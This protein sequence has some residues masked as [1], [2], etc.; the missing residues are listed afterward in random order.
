M[1]DQIEQTP[2]E[3]SPAEQI[4]D[5]IRK[6]IQELEKRTHKGPTPRGRRAA[7]VSLAKGVLDYLEQGVFDRT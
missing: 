2:A 7:A 5:A 1:G 3:N 4:W 6:V